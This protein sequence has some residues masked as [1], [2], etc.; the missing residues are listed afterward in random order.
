MDRFQSDAEIVKLVAAAVCSGQSNDTIARHF[1]NSG[2]DDNR[3]K[4]MIRQMKALR[5]QPR[6]SRSFGLVWAGLAVMIPGLFVSFATEGELIWY[7]P[8]VVGFGI[9]IAGIFRLVNGTPP[10]RTNELAEAWIN[11]YG[12]GR[13]SA[14]N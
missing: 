6:A 10:L 3:V 11:Q 4:E 14:P 1:A 12:A 7:G 13:H 8:V 9:C 2:A 5:T